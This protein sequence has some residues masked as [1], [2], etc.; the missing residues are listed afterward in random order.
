MLGAGRTEPDGYLVRRFPAGDARIID[1]ASL[2][3]NHGV[4]E[5]PAAAGQARKGSQQDQGEKRPRPT[6]DGPEPLLEA[7]MFLELRGWASSDVTPPGAPRRPASD[8]EI[9]RDIAD[10]LGV[11]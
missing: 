8:R 3:G 6:F 1:L 4:G 5:E 11:L 7:A 9:L 10:R 2:R